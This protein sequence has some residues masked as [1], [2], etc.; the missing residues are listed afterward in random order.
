MIAP[1]RSL[2]EFSLVH[3]HPVRVGAA[4]S[5]RSDG[6]RRALPKR[7]PTT[8]AVGVCP[9]GSARRSSVLAP[10]VGQVAP[11]RVDVVRAVLRVV[12]L[13]EEPRPADRVVV[14]A[15][16]RVRPGPGEGDARRARRRG[17]APTPSPRPRSGSG[18]GSGGS[19]P[20]VRARCASSQR[21]VADADR[22]AAQRRPGDRRRS[23]CPAARPGR[24]SRRA[25]ARASALASSARASVSS[26]VRARSA[27]QRAVGARPPGWRRGTTAPRPR[28][29]PSDDGQLDRDVVATDPPRPRRRRRVGIAED[30]EPVPVRVAPVQPDR[31]ARTLELTEDRL[32]VD[33]RTDLGRAARA[34]RRRRRPPSRPPVAP[35][36]SRRGPGP[37]AGPG[38]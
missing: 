36:P 32:E 1:L 38:V 30:G 35:R 23:G 17:S 5:S 29:R 24:R 10:V 2:D 21:V 11:D 19:G 16:R 18:R 26:P 9:P 12:V 37:R 15:A 22:D 7:F 33:D 3:G 31:P 34:H 25:A 28:S 6:S 20:R 4:V 8:T 13:D 27:G 14:T